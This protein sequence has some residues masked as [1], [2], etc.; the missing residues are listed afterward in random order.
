M[1]GLLTE[2]AVDVTYQIYFCSLLPGYYIHC[3]GLM[4][5]DDMGL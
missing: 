5:Y 4:G 1:V 2:P 3:C